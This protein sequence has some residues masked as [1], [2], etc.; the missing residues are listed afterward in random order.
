MTVVDL[1]DGTLVGV[2]VLNIRSE[3]RLIRLEPL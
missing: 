2:E 1:S 3:V